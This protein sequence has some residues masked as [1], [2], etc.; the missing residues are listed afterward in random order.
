MPWYLWLLHIYLDCLC[1]LGLRSFIS[2]VMPVCCAST[3]DWNFMRGGCAWVESQ[4]IN[5]DIRWSTVRTVRTEIELLG[6][7]GGLACLLPVKELGALF[8]WST[9]SYCNWSAGRWVNEQ[10]RKQSEILSP[11]Q[12]LPPQLH[13]SIRVCWK[14]IFSRFNDFKGNNI[15][16]TGSTQWQVIEISISVLDGGAYGWRKAQVNLKSNNTLFESSWKTMENRL[17]GNLSHLITARAESRIKG[18]NT[19]A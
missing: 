17:N 19:W 1:S 8:G 18:L 12:E 2:I 16:S 5:K 7:V 14:S 9:Q 11:T 15:S 3:E 6:L 4:S 10:Q 13:L